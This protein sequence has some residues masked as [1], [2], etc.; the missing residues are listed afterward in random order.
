M[1]RFL[2]LISRPRKYGFTGEEVRQHL[3]ESR[4]HTVYANHLDSGMWW[5]KRV[6]I[7]KTHSACLQLYVT[8]GLGSTKMCFQSGIC[9]L[10]AEGFDPGSSDKCG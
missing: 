1:Y 5:G 10:W 8:G 3:P 9:W 7:N 6:S 2:H 4:K